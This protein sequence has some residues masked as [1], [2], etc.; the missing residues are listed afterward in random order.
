[1]NSFVE[2]NVPN[3]IHNIQSVRKLSGDALFMA[4]VKSN[5]YG[6]GMVELSLQI[7]SFVDRFGVNSM[8]EAIQLIHS[9]ITKPVHILSPYFDDRVRE[10][11]I[12]TID[13]I[14]DLHRYDSICENKRYEGRFHLK[15]NTGMNRFGLEIEQL[16]DFIEALQRCDHI[17]MEGVFSHFGSTYGNHRS[18]TKKQWDKFMFC[19]K[20]ISMIYNQPMIFHIANSAACI[21]FPQSRLDMVRIGNA[22]YGF[23]SSKANIGLLPTFLVKTSVM[24]VRFVNKGEYVGYGCTF[25][26][27]QNMWIA[28][29]AFGVYDGFG[30]TRTRKSFL[31]EIYLRFFPR[32]K[33]LIQKQHI[34]TLGNPSMT[35]ILAD[36]TSINAKPGEEVILKVDSILSLKETIKRKYVI[37]T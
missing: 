36:V 8:D 22:M 33:L 19:K 4:I 20:R 11:I 6:L 2:V 27:K 31:R 37:P 15:I 7:Q 35:Y 17:T 12:P 32:P 30:L 9:G 1:M 25:K 23:L 5:A 3:V 21:D 34:K 13:N 10:G 18:F 28:V 14:A 24:S 29:I 16:D 26:A